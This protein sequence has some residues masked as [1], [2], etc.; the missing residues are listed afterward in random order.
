MPLHELANVFNEINSIDKDYRKSVRNDKAAAHNKIAKHM[1]H[2]LRLYMMGIDILQEGKIITYREEEHDLLMDIRYGKYLLDDQVTPTDEFKTLLNS[3][4]E[5]WDYAIEHT[6]LPDQPDLD[7]INDLV[8][9]I[10]K[11][12]YN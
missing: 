5:K 11:S 2:L 12:V 8:I 3:Y 9:Q 6:S 4:I 10:F 1:M 7:K